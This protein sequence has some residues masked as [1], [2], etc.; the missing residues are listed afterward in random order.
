MNAPDNIE[1]FS[2]ATRAI[3]RR[4]LESFPRPIRLH[5]L[6]LQQELVKLAE[7][8]ES[9]AWREGSGCL[10]ESTLEYLAAEGVIRFAEKSVPFGTDEQGSLCAVFIWQGV[11]LTAKGFSV[12]N[13]PFPES[14]TSGNTIAK[15]IRG[16]GALVGKTSVTE[17]VRLLFQS[18]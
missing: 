17:A 16:A 8:P 11:T 14:A 12:L 6:E 5:S 13:R 2:L 18:L 15:A 9:C 4:L 1:C 7:L 10:V 3:L